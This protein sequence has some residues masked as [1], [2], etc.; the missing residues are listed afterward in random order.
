MRLP[1][2][3]E[4]WK[5]LNGNSAYL[6]EDGEMLNMFDP[7]RYDL[8]QKLHQA[9]LAGMLKRLSEIRESLSETLKP[10]HP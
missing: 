5:S 4:K 8:Y 2:R 10:I 7:E 1:V 9:S 6:R 3:T